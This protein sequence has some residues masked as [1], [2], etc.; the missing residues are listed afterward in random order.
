[1]S[2]HH[3][4]RNQSENIVFNN[5]KL[6]RD[7]NQLFDIS[8]ICEDGTVHQAHKVVLASQSERF[9]TILNHLS[10]SGVQ[11]TSIFLTG[12][13]G[14]ELENILDFLYVGEAK[15]V[16]EK[17][18]RFLNVASLLHI[19]SLLSEDD[20][21]QDFSHLSSSST[22]RRSPMMKR[23]QTDDTE[24]EPIVKNEVDV[25]E[26]EE[27]DYD[28]N[29]G[30]FD[31]DNDNDNEQEEE[32]DDVVG[33]ASSV[34]I[35]IVQQSP[36]KV[37]S[38]VSKKKGKRSSRVVEN[39]TEDESAKVL[40]EN[41]K[42]L[43]MSKLSNK[44]IKDTKTRKIVKKI[45]SQPMRKLPCP[46]EYMNTEQLI[47]WMKNEILKDIIEQGKR[48]VTRIKWGDEACRPSC[49]PEEIFPWHLVT[50][51]SHGQTMKPEHV[52]TVE[53]WKMVVINRLRSKGINP[54]DYVSEE[55]TEEEVNSKMRCRGIS[56]PK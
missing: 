13:K 37:I 25:D 20:A 11:Q 5:I 21:R 23:K 40:L 32:S 27:V 10:S 39:V 6:L 8:L 43:G 30:G 19:N 52:N 4:L 12:V 24:L 7:E 56:C 28:D 42:A 15:V 45:M 44:M 50:N 2:P 9:K 22:S 36:S 18:S 51:P 26:D 53:T 41:L 48:P 54:E 47:K 29:Y 1:M 14:S 35:P 17:L 34:C 55:C 46:V 16:Q 3:V 38:K 33:E 31:V 49:W